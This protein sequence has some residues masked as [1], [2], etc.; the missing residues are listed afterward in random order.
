MGLTLCIKEIV[1]INNE[2]INQ[3]FIISITNEKNKENENINIYIINNNIVLVSQ[4]NW[5][6]S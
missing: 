5:N 6:I 4:R 3:D 1:N 2:I